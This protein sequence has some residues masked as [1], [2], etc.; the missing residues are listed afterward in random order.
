MKVHITEKSLEG[1]R[2]MDNREQAPAIRSLNGTALFSAQVKFYPPQ[3]TGLDHDI[4]G[5]TI[6]T[7][8][9]PDP[10]DNDR[11]AQ[12]YMK[13]E[14]TGPSKHPSHLPVDMHYLGAY[15]TDQLF[16]AQSPLPKGLPSLQRE[17]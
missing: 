14:M 16:S 8:L 11:K 1:Q 10:T 3:Q 6:E 4:A 5:H 12:R 13:N 17:S 7:R 2:E 9:L 15:Q